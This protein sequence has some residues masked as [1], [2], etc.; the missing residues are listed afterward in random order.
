[1]TST[2]ILAV[3]QGSRTLSKS[4][5]EFGKMDPDGF[6][7][8]IIAMTV[9]FIALIL[10]YLTFKYVSKLYSVDLKK[11]FRKEKPGEKVPGE[12]EEIPGEVNAVIALALHMYR[13]Q[14]HD[15]EDA[16][17]TIKKVA[18]AY[19]PWSSKIYGLRKTPRI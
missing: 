5:E 2:I 11:K 14:L 17:I 19:S 9:V 16:V 6:V 8:T 12:I 1:M 10:L 18:K 7:M 13:N 15:M 3:Q 4:A